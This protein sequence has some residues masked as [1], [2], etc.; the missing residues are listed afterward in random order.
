MFLLM[1]GGYLQ[2][3]QR[4]IAAAPVLKHDQGYRRIDD[5]ARPKG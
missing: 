1:P 3:V 5:G 2:H 4:R